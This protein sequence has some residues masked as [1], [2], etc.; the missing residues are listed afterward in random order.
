[1]CEPDSPECYLV[2]RVMHPLETGFYINYQISVSEA[3]KREKFVDNTECIW[4]SKILAFLHTDKIRQIF[5]QLQISKF[6]FC[7][8]YCAWEVQRC[9]ISCTGFPGPEAVSLCSTI[10]TQLHVVSTLHHQAVLVNLLSSS[11]CHFLKKTY[12]AFSFAKCQT[13]FHT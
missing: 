1:M 12:I 10:Q 9:L 7:S 2:S 6:T 3:Q 4:L 8:G 11:I 5:K 13:T